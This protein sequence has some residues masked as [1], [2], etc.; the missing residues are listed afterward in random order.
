M[1]ITLDT[2]MGFDQNNSF[3]INQLSYVV[4]IHD[5]IVIFDSSYLRVRTSDID[6]QY[7]HIN[8]TY[9]KSMY[10]N[11]YCHSY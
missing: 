1:I 7:V 9:S 11:V 3:S 4:N 8:H 2:F 5:S 10:Q 6:K